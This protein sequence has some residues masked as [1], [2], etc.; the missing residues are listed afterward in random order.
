MWVADVQERSGAVVD[1]LDRAVDGAAAQVYVEDVHEDTDTD[2]VTTEFAIGSDV[3]Y[4]GYSPVGGRNEKALASRYVAFG[5]AEKPKHP[6]VDYQH[7]RQDGR[8]SPPR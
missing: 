8:N 5:V 4:I 3:G 1:R 2:P 7:G 6:H